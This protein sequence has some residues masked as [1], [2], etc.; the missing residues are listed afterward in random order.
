MADGLLEV[1]LLENA[2]ALF[3]TGKKSDIDLL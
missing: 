2:Y 3:N 1:T